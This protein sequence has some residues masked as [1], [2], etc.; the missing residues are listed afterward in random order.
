MLASGKLRGSAC[1][2]LG[3]SRPMLVNLHELKS[4]K[5]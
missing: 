1:S 5:T 4:E 2:Y 3:S